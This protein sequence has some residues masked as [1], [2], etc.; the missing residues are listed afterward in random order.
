MHIILFL[1]YKSYL[2]G[3]PNILKKRTFIYLHF[4]YQFF[5]NP[6]NLRFRQEE[7]YWGQKLKI[8]RLKKKTFSGE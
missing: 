1:T 6:L 4:C 2:E 7:I 3:F 8:Y 5:R